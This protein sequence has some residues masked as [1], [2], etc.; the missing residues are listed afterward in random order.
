M[1]LLAFVVIIVSCV[2]NDQ[3]PTATSSPVESTTTTLAQATT[4]TTDT[5]V[6]TTTRAGV[7]TTTALGIDVEITG[8]E[9]VGP[10]TFEFALG[11]PVDIWILSDGDDEIHV[12]GYD[13]RFD[14]IA[15]DPLT[16]S[17]EA[18]VPGIF[19]VE[20]HGRRGPL[21]D[22]EVTG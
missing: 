10:A 21:F 2:S 6:T 8:G 20:A 9:V 13:L 3:S 17:F 19:E 22:I 14:L 12:H 5:I 15:G 16:L 18:D 11:E 1:A 7:T 4:T